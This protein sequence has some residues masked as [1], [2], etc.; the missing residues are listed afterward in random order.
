[1]KKGDKELH[2]VRALQKRLIEAAD[3]TVET[4]GKVA[5]ATREVLQEV[6]QAA[7]ISS[8]ARDVGDKMRQ[9]KQALDQ[10]YGLTEK[11]GQL[12][13]QVREVTGQVV[14]AGAVLVEKSGAKDL[15][16]Q[17]AQRAREAVLDPAREAIRKTG[18]D[19]AMDE[20]LGKLEHLYGTTRE[21]IKPYFA[22]EDT[23]E[24]LTNTR[25][26]LANVSACLMQISSSDSEKLASQFSSAVLAKATGAAATTTLM[27]LVAAYGTAG[28]GTAI[29]S[30]SGAAAANATLAWVGGLLGGGMATGAVLTGGIALVA[31]L[32]AYKLLGSERRDF[33]SLSETEQRMVQTCWLA[34]AIIDEYLAGPPE[35][36]T[37]REA[38]Q[39]LVNV[40]RPLL[41]ELQR[42]REEI[43][44]N[45]DGKHAVA[46]RQ[47]I[48][49]DFRRV[50]IE[51][52]E[53]FIAGYPFKGFAGAEYVIGGVFY[54]LLSQSAVGAELES[55]L[56]LDALRRS[57]NA[58]ADASE[59]EL[60]EYL[61]DLSPEALKGL[62]ANVKGIYHE[63]L[64]VHNYNTTHSDTYAEVFGATNHPGA[65]I[66]IR[67]AESG[68]IVEQIQLK[69]VMEAAKVEVHLDKYPDI[70]V[71]ATNEVADK[72]TD[73]RVGSSGHDNETLQAR[74]DEDLAAVADNSIGDRAGDA[75]LLAA[76]IASTRELLEMLRGERDFPDAAA[77]ALKGAGVA[78][79]ATVLAAYLFG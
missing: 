45:L 63:L 12:G 65:D 23:R 51:G 10:R 75:A 71:L 48:L 54:A 43:C 15:A 44:A 41:E 29:A 55:Q 14:D 13:A 27:A 37:E 24:L 4:A 78:G 25:Q 60:G 8:G 19:Q 74:V 77:N 52:F 40:F 76:G 62:A 6:D 56:V 79:A 2:W 73:A 70:S 32:A 35:E 69:A 68:E 33:E 50:V 3:R 64:Y 53:G 42:H 16:E 11:A 46:F 36:F 39:L 20:T 9:T 61:R 30:L 5:G 49:T 72:F 66:Q 1:M 22:A 47:H 67:D 28:T 38:E 7:G 59:A 34:I 18:V 21:V 57:S 58:L 17:A 26:E 31:G